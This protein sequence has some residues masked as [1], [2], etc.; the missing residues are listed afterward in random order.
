M[1]GLSILEVL[2]ELNPRKKKL[3][4]KDY[5]F[6]VVPSI[7]INIAEVVLDITTECSGSLY[8]DASRRY[9]RQ[10]TIGLKVIGTFY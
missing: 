9:I 1:I 10:S 6:A 5:W 8:G 7:I 2:E 3:I 4:I